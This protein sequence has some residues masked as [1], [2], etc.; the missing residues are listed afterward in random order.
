MASKYEWTAIDDAATTVI[1]NLIKQANLSYQGVSD[2]THGAI[3]KSRVSDI[4]TSRRSPLRL[5]E[6]ILLI[7]VLGKTAE[8]VITQINNEAQKTPTSESAKIAEGMRRASQ[9][10]YEPVADRSARKQQYIDGER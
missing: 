2:K 1:A 9:S 7:D 5:S 10:D 3:S 8:E 4:V 6:F